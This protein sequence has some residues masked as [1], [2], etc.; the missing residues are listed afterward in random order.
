MTILWRI[1]EYANLNGEGG[2]T[3]SARWH[4]MGNPI[5]YLAE[6]PAGAMLERIVHLWD[7]VEGELPRFYQLLEVSAPDEIAIKPLIAIAPVDW[8]EQQGSTRQ[9]GNVWLSSRETP[10]ARVPS[11]IVPHTSNYFLN[12]A[13]PDA[14]RIKIVSKS[15]ER[16]DSRLFH[17]GAP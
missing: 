1:S 12:P 6:S 8:K 11:A 17:F 14:I 5:V 3:G 10:L 16:F 13:H 7:D 15:R 9:L 4:T 2:R